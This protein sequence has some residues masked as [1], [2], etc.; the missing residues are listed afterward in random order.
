MQIISGLA[1]GLNLEVVKGMDIR[2][3]TARARKSLF[4]SLSQFEELTVLDLFAGA[5]SLGFEAASRGA[6]KVTFVEKNK[7]HCNILKKN[8]D[9][10]FKCSNHCEFR[11]LNWDIEEFIAS[12]CE[13]FDFI[14]SD[15]PY[16]DSLGHFKKILNSK[17]FLDSQN[18]K[19][20]LIW[21]IPAKETNSYDFLDIGLWQNF[22]VRNF[23][24]IKFLIIKQN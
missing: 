22:T 11:I 19:S 13:N 20:N 2:P 10:F 18:S 15:P 4:D 9:N 21:E 24:G 17:I 8:I 5:G 6:T 23:G 16:N 14:F 12:K 1:K 3:T 7:L